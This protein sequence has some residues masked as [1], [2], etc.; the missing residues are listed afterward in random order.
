MAKLTLGLPIWALAPFS[1]WR[2]RQVARRFLTLM[3]PIPPGATLLD[4]GGPGMATALVAAPFQSVIVANISEEALQ[5]GHLAAADAFRRLL[6]DG[7]AL[8][9]GENSVDFVFSDNVIEHICEESRDSFVNELR[10]VAARG[11]L[12]TTPNY[13]FPFEPHYHMPLFQYLPGAARGRLLRHARFGFVDDAGETIKLLSRRDLR[14]LVP[15][16]TVSGIGFTPYPETLVASWRRQEAP[17]TSS[18][19]RDGPALLAAAGRRA[20][21]PG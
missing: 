10:R 18:D 12:I 6:G 9:L 17:E 13:W 20:V 3:S 19:R 16:A 11:F 8:P 14:R 7:C 4:V 5:P 21:P 2:R 15:E 1:R